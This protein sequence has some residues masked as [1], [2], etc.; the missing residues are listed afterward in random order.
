MH[1]WLI[2]VNFWLDRIL[3][4]TLTVEKIIACPG[5]HVVTTRYSKYQGVFENGMRNHGVPFEKLGSR[6]GLALAEGYHGRQPRGVHDT[7]PCLEGWFLPGKGTAIL[8]W[9]H[10][11]G[12]R[13]ALLK[14]H[15]VIKGGA[16]ALFDH[17]AL[18]LGAA[19]QFAANYPEQGWLPRFSAASSLLPRPPDVEVRSQGLPRRHSI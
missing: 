17:E 16:D 11:G 5:G 9:A 6:H 10:G 13:Y 3:P 7:A 8:P 4:V 2:N 15:A 19:L 14:Q 1:L 18:L 12:T